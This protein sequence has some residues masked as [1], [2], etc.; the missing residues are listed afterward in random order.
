MARLEIKLVGDGAEQLLSNGGEP[1]WD[2]CQNQ[3]E[4]FEQYLRQNVPGWEDGMAKWE[5]WIVAA[6]LCHALKGHI[7]EAQLKESVSP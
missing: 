3:T 1:L 2:L 6:H 4:N 5:R 7:E